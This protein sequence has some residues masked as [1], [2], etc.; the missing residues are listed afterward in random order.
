[1]TDAHP[2]L[3]ALPIR[4]DEA[5]HRYIWGPTGE[6]L[7]YSVTQIC[8]RKTEAQIAAIEATRHEWEPRGKMIHLFGE[9]LLKSFMP[10][11]EP[12]LKKPS[13]PDPGPYERWTT[14]LLEKRFWQDW[15]TLATEFRLCD[16]NRSIGGSLD[17]LGY[18]KGRLCLID[19]KS[20]SS[21][22]SSQYDISAQLG[23]YV[24][25]LN[26]H[27]GLYVEECRGVWVKPGKTI[28]STSIEPDTCLLAFN[29]CWERFQALQESE[30][31]W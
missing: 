1:M 24:R 6:V 3:E 21:I 28:V 31:D 20:Q 2:P 18:Y 22:K 9:A 17:G 26:D 4:F 10:R 29:D 13:L 27:F 5:A 8:N 16:L 19:F 7:A 15:E 25:M 30:N 12:F 23:G 14:P 11:S